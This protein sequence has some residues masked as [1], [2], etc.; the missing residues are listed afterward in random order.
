MVDAWLKEMD[1]A[2]VSRNPRRGRGLGK[3]ILRLQE[4][5]VFRRETVCTGITVYKVRSWGANAASKAEGQ[6]L[7]RGMIQ[8]YFPMKTQP[9]R[10]SKRTLRTGLLKAQRLRLGLPEHAQSGTEGDQRK[11]WCHPLPGSEGPA[12]SRAP[13]PQ[14]VPTVSRVQRSLG[15]PTQAPRSAK[16]CQGATQLAC[17]APLASWRRLVLGSTH[18]LKDLDSE[19]A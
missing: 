7:T 14:I 3:E 19:G 12:L 15:S 16:W 11:A 4:P 2:R 9:Q 8:A 10:D 17:T 1:L 13:L 18:G 5:N 6:W